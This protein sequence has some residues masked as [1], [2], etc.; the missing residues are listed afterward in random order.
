LSSGTAVAGRVPTAAA[1]RPARLWLTPI[2]GAALALAL[3]PL[4]FLPAALALGLLF[5][6]LQGARGYWPAFARA[7]LFGFGFHLAGLYWVG[8]AF[9]AEADRFGALA[10][11]GVVA[12]AAILAVIGAMPLALLGPL[13]LRQ[14]IA[15]A[16]VFAGL[17]CLGELAR[18]QHGVQ[19]PWNPLALALAATDTSLQVVAIVG[20][21]AGGFLVAWLA[22][23]VGVAL[24][25]RAARRT[26]LALCLAMVAGLAAFGLWRLDSHPPGL[27]AEPPVTV[28]IVQANIAQHHKWDPAL[29]RNWFDRHL[30]L[31][32]Q[33]IQPDA[34]DRPDIVVWPESSVP[35]S[36][37][38]EP[39]VRGL[40]GDV[41]RPG[42]VV[43]LGSNHF[44]GSVE[45]PI[46]HNSVYALAGDGE[47]LGRY[48]KVDLVPFGEF[49]PMR[50]L[51]GAVGLE[52][53]A[54]G[55]MDF[56]AGPGRTTMALPGLPPA[57]PLVCFEAAFPGRGT[58]GS[59]RARWIVN[60]TNDA[61]FG[62]SSGPYQHAAMARMRAVET[63]LPL[64]RAAN[65]GISM[66]T[67]P[68][69]R[70]LDSLPLGTTG[71]IDASLPAALPTS[72]PIT[73]WPWLSSLLMGLALL[74]AGAAELAGRRS[75]PRDRD[76]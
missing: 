21:T 31:A 16:A 6:Q 57:S 7:W 32:R 40:I 8:I 51:L 75:S 33:P 42:G 30:D 1:E 15:A 39:E 66:L 58:D 28:R 19:F 68:M 23:L 41:V 55:S 24:T 60:V 47:L 44:D 34:P 10:V 76:H 9:L 67:D 54:V 25:V 36:L 43:I 73:R 22:A 17:W 72:P 52:A 50:P 69:G 65:T 20:T 70:V 2:A 53:L 5:V 61:W 48:D 45:P 46:L 3:P 13:R 38:A 37:D 14:P 64:V 62:I 56:Q 35:Y 63:G 59:G 49:L 18:G 29:R 12:L 74:A 26:A 71:T 4:G 27:M 11:P